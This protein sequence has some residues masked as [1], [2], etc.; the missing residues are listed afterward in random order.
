LASEKARETRWLG[1]AGATEQKRGRDK[2]CPQGYCGG[3]RNSGVR[4]WQPVEDVALGWDASSRGLERWED[5]EAT[6]GKGGAQ[7]MTGGGQERRITPAAGRTRGQSREQRRQEE[8]RGRNE[9]ED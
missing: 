7:E 8:E 6:R 5:G 2:A 9:A 1:V 3:G 4:C